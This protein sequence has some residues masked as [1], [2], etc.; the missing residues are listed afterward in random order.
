MSI[1]DSSL[2]SYFTLLTDLSDVEI[3]ALLAGAPMEAKK[4]LAFEI[5]SGLHDPAAAEAARDYFESTFQRRQTPEQMQEYALGADG[6]GGP[7]GRLDHV[8]V[9]ADLA[10]SGAE[11]RRLVQQG[12]VRV[13]GEPVDTFDR[14]VH[15]GDELRVGRRRF[16][17]LVA[18]ASDA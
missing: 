11:V 14:A 8:L 10:Q 16:L 6:V 2:R 5:T 17:R 13:N 15:P 7:A 1:P 3:E 18:E 4:R 12:A 9:D